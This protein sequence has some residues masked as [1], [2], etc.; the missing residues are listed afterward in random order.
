MSYGPVRPRLSRYLYNK[1][2]GE[3]SLPRGKVLQ[4]TLSV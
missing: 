1:N 4:L 2:R 3:E